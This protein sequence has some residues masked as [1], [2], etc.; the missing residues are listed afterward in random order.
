MIKKIHNY[1]FEEGRLLYL[2]CLCIIL[3]LHKPIETLLSNTIVK[4]GLSEI[5]TIWFNDLLFLVFVF[6]SVVFAIEKFNSYIP[7]K[8]F[9]FILVFFTGAYC[10]YR[11]CDIVWDFA[12]FS[13]STSVKYGDVLILITMF[14][15]LLFYKTKRGTEDSNIIGF[16]NDEAIS[17]SEEDNLGYESYAK[18]IAEKIKNSKFKKAF[19][20]GIN[21]KWG[22]GKTSFIQMLKEQIDDENII[23][24]DFNSWNSNS[25]KAVIQDFFENLQNKL[26]PYQAS[27]SKQLQLYSEKL[28]SL[29]DSNFSQAI[30]ASLSV[31]IGFSSLNDLYVEIDDSLKRIDK[32]IIV[33]I[34]DLDRLDKDEIIEVLR[35]IRNTANFR[36]TFFIVAYDRHYV[37]NALESHNSFKKEEFLEKIF[38]IEIT[39]PYFDRNILRKKLA[40]KLVFALPNEFR[41]DIEN[42]VLGS[43]YQKPL[44]LND[45]LESIRDVNRLANSL[46]INL[47]KLHG[48]VYLGDFIKLELLRLKCAPVY[49]L[50]FNKTSTFLELDT[51]SKKNNFYKLKK[52]EKNG[53]A[54]LTKLRDCYLDDYIDEYYNDLLIN[55]ASKEKIVDLVQSL[56]GSGNLNSFEIRSNLSVVFPSKFDRYFAYTLLE[57]SLSEVEFS[58]ARLDSQENFNQKISKWVEEGLEFEIKNKFS[59]ISK[60]DNKEDLERV[61]KAIFYFANLKSKRNGITNEV[62]LVGFDKTELKEKLYNYDKIIDRLYYED[63]EYNFKDFLKELFQNAKPPFTFESQLIRFFNEEFGDDFV[64]DKT[65]LKDISIGY[66]KRFAEE[67]KSFDKVIFRLFQSCLQTSWISNGD[68]SS[69]RREE[70]MPFEAKM[71]LKDFILTEDLNGFLLFVIN[72]D[73]IKPPTFIVS[74]FAKILFGSWM[75]FIMELEKQDQSKWPYLREFKLFLS[76][77]EKKNFNESI[78]FEFKEI[79]VEVNTF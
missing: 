1:I 40:E 35:L 18:V 3:I 77:F 60:Y 11:F 69:Y 23:K 56:F 71:I 47:S 21:G 31:F 75:E 9:F 24:I 5:E 28:I 39:L 6:I 44:Y 38:Q 32:K 29:N 14:Y 27:L 62:V 68:G 74:N 33:Y 73:S 2:L 58:N 30:H 76:E 70:E 61:I 10:T 78:P 12:S 64:L 66:L 36:N 43:I 34:D 37:I 46:M 16:F 13:F 17:N 50:L 45:W 26:S 79:P 7:S 15:S 22:L 63:S 59:K 52:S 57:G 25:P 41:E 20:I 55:K 51:N 67:S 65:E 4:Y 49:E 54:D 72:Q 53:T 42:E 8:R 48:E 19:A